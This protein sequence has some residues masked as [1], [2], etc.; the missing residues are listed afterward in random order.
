[1]N[2]ATPELAAGLSTLRESGY[3]GEP[4]AMYLAGGLAVN[5]YCGTRLHD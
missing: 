1:M 5:Y 3:Q 4:I 2:H